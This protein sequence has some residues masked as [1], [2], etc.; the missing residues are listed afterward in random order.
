M[1]LAAPALGVPSFPKSPA[2]RS[3][4]AAPFALMRSDWLAR[5]STPALFMG[6]SPTDR[7]PA[8]R[9]DTPPTPDGL[10]RSGD[11]GTPADLLPTSADTAPGRATPPG[12]RMLGE[13]LAPIPNALAAGL[14]AT[15]CTTGCAGLASMG[16]GAEEET[17]D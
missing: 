13:G 2:K 17:A 15:D 1:T 7:P 9:L 14:P 3:T 8:Y 5:T 10:D 6:L 4:A 12:D 11:C 16:P